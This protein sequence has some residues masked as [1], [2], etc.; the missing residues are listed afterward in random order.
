MRTL[1]YGIRDIRSVGPSGSPAPHPVH[2]QA[3]KAAMDRISPKTKAIYDFLRADFDKSDRDHV[4]S[5]T[6]AI[7]KLDAKLY[8]LSSRIDEVKF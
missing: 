1:Q 6:A 8:L 5:K 3:A 2:R 4:D 7:C